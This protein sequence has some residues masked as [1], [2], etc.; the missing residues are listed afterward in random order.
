MPEPRI[1]INK[2]WLDYADDFFELNLDLSN[3]QCSVIF[4]IYTDNEELYKLKNG[5]IEFSNFKQEEFIWISGEDVEN[6]THFLSL[7]FFLYDK[8]G[9]VGIEVTADNKQSSPH[10]VRASFVIITV[11]SQID[12]FIKKL[13]S[14]VNKE[15]NVLEGIIQSCDI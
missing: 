1:K 12:D 5:I 14:F 8:R 2:I 15:I 3:D 4:D 9:Y 10:G 6:V 13:E 7:R 11:L